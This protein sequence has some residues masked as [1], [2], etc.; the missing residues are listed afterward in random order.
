LLKRG[1]LGTAAPLY[2]DLALLFEIAMGVALLIGWLL[3]RT[4]RYR[5]HAWCQSTIVLLNFAVV[6][7][8]MAPS[9]RVAVAPAI[10]GNLGN[11]YYAIA[12]VHATVGALAEI[13]GLYVLVAAGT[14]LLPERLRLT[15]YKL[16]MRILLALWWFVLLLGFATYVQWYMP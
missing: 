16:W 15:R 12:A 4:R 13:G 8:V 7:L 2:A 9:F 5:Q 3:A 10:P 11:A 1:F 14:K 6:A